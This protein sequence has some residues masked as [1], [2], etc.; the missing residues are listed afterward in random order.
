MGLVELQLKLTD[1]NILVSNL[2]K[3]LTCHVLI[4]AILESEPNTYVSKKIFV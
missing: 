4:I 1:V 2:Q 3:N